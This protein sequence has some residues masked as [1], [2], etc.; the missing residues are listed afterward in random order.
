MAEA[1]P[2]IGLL[3]AIPQIMKYVVELSG[4]LSSVSTSV[5]SASRSIQQWEDQLQVCLDLIAELETH[6]RP[7][8]D[9]TQDII[10]LW[11]EEANIIKTLLKDLKTSRGDGK[12]ARVGKAMKLIKRKKDM[13]QRLNQLSGTLHQRYMQ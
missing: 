1:I 11:N 8:D 9:L 3:V 12:F 4:E 5:R 2:I 6:H 13:T 7:S 10:T